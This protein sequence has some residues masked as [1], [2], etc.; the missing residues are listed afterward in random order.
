MADKTLWFIND[1]GVQALGIVTRSGVQALKLHDT[2]PSPSVPFGRL[3]PSIV[4][5]G[6]SRTLRKAILQQDIV[7]K[8]YYSDFLSV[9]TG[10]YGF[11]TGYCGTKKSTPEQYWFAG[12][13][14]TS[15]RTTR[16]FRFDGSTWT[17]YT[18]GFTQKSPSNTPLYLPMCHFIVPGDTPDRP[19]V[20]TRTYTGSYGSYSD[21]YMLQRWNGSSWDVLLDQVR[22]VWKASYLNPSCLAVLNSYSTGSAPA[23]NSGYSDGIEWTLSNNPPT[24]ELNMFPKTGGNYINFCVALRTGGKGL[25]QNRGY[26]EWCFSYTYKKIGATTNTFGYAICRITGPDTVAV[27]G[28]HYEADSPYTGWFTPQWFGYVNGNY[29]AVSAG[30]GGGGG[31]D[32]YNIS[33]DHLNPVLLSFSWSGDGYA[34]N[35]RYI[36]TSHFPSVNHVRIYDTVTNSEIPQADFNILTGYNPIMQLYYDAPD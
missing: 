34:Y 16:I 5:Y 3:F 23:V 35:D 33:N 11:S 27:T 24:V 14:T 10:S 9:P 8:W 30:G 1:G 7:P 32:L 22:T 28:P 2:C 18:A 31:G 25:S 6:A 36:F 26:T 29:W 21:T 19:G 12:Q 15:P 20:W 13:S 4:Y 17:E